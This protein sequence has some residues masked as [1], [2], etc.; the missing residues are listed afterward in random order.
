[1]MQKNVEFENSSRV[2]FPFAHL[3][4][5]VFP[6]IALFVTIHSTK[7]IVCCKTASLRSQHSLC[8]WGSKQKNESNQKIS[9]K[10]W[11]GTS[12]QPCSV[13]H[14]FLN[15]PQDN[16]FEIEC[17]LVNHFEPSQPF[18]HGSLKKEVGAYFVPSQPFLCSVNHFLQRSQIHDYFEPSQPFWFQSTI[19]T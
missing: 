16:T 15:Q 3:P 11:Q 1:M 19:L 12:S 2:V 18:C 8:Q 13:N 14:G 17:C 7:M 10:G 4:P 5:F 9:E 6:S